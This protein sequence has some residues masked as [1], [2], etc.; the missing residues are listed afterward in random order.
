MGFFTFF[1]IPLSGLLLVALAYLIR[2]CT[3]RRLTVARPHGGIKVGAAK[4]ALEAN[5]MSGEEQAR[6]GGYMRRLAGG[7]SSAFH[8]SPAAR[9]SLRASAWLQTDGG[10]DLTTRVVT[11]KQ[12]SPAA[13]IITDKHGGVP[14]GVADRSGKNRMVDIGGRVMNMLTPRRSATPPGSRRHRRPSGGSGGGSHRAR[15][16]F[17]LIAHTVSPGAANAGPGGKQLPEPKS[18]KV[19]KLCT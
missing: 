10:V 4:F 6:D 14:V 8:P 2:C 18:S 11:D 15:D 9:A 5:G 13:K 1:V 19:C 3:M 16:I 17:N 12:F 7:L